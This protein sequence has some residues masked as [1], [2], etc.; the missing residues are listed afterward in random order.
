MKYQ[1]AQIN[2]ARMKGLSIDDPEM[3][4][5]RDNTDR[6]NELAETSPGFIWR[7][8]IDTEAPKEPNVLNDEQ[9]LINISVWEDVAS[10]RNFT[11]KTFHSEFIKRQKEWFQK[12]GTAH[13]VLWWIEAGQ[14]PSEKEAIKRLDYLEEHGASE[15]GFTF[16][17]IFE[18]PE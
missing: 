4:D 6:V 9:V 17:Q 10:L 1:L 13:Y 5:F 11:Y 12:Y 3:K 2:V 18:R 16:R 14:F 15:Q 7:D 8:S